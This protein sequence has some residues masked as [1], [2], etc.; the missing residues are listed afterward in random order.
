M[1]RLF[2]SLILIM[3]LLAGCNVPVVPGIEVTATGMEPSEPPAAAS[4]TADTAP[5]TSSS[6]TA[7]PEATLP[8]ATVTPV[9]SPQAETASN[10]IAF[11]GSDGNLWL[12]ETLS[13]ELNQVTQE[14]VSFMAAGDRESVIF[15]NPQWSSDGQLVAYQREYRKPVVDG[16]E[17]QVSLWVYDLASN[18]ARE[19]LAD[20]QTA[21]YA[22]RPGTHTIAFAI[23]IEQDY[24]NNQGGVDSS[25]ARGIQAYDVDS[26]TLSELVAPARGYSLSNPR[27]SPD[28]TKIGFEEIIYMEGSGLFAYVDLTTN[29]YFP[30]EKALGGF[31]W[32]P[33]G[34]MVAYDYLTYGPSGTERIYLNDLRNSSERA[35]SPVIVSGYAYSPRFSPQGDR[36]AYIAEEFSAEG[37]SRYKILI[38]GLDET[39]PRELGL[40]DQPGYL[41]WSPDG[42]WLLLT[43]GNYDQSQMIMV[44]V[45]DGSVK[46]LEQGIQPVWQP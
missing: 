20:E 23:P 27:F 43:V 17:Y 6:A 40:F 2:L 38:Q 12:Q 28:G 39:L 37:N 29:E 26:G 11:I 35:L 13:G 25:L 30:W 36:V 32:S 7:Q 42:E 14:G 18:Q 34:E 24:F 8:N 45:A 1:L 3:L 10:R 9:E 31:A 16:M 22:W 33:D 44:N 5:P 15:T 41:S 21:G 4:P 19:V 46:P